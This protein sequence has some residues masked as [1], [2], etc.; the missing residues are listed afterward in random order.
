MAP[1]P[2]LATALRRD[3]QQCHWQRPK[4]MPRA[5]VY[6]EAMTEFSREVQALV[7]RSA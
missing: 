6:A 2:T 3:T 7:A 4:A 1:G 5:D